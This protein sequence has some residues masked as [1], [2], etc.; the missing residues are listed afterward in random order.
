MNKTENN[1]IIFYDGYCNLCNLSVRLILKYEK[2]AYYQFS[3]LSSDFSK[4]YLNK[5]YKSLTSSNTILLI[6]NNE[7]YLKSDA[8]LKIVEQFKFP[9]NYLKYIR[10]IPKKIRDFFYDLLAKYRYAVFGRKKTCKN[11]SEKLKHRFL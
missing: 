11:P 1:A 5:D 6:E 7:V 9:L 3:S 8:I 4:A 2:N 10:Y